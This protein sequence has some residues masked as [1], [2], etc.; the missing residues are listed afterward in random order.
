MRIFHF[1]QILIKIIK[2]DRIKGIKM[3]ILWY[4]IWFNY[5]NNKLTKFLN[6]YSAIPFA[7]LGEPEMYN[8]LYNK[9]NKYLHE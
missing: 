1:I 6:K 8:K 9:R 7:Y 4:K 3:K 2:T 5:Y